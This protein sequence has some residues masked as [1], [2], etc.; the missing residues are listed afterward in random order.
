EQGSVAV[1]A[2]VE[3]RVQRPQT[4]FGLTDN[5]LARIFELVGKQVRQLVDGNDRGGGRQL[6]GGDEVLAVRRGIQAVGVLRYWNVASDLAVLAILLAAVEH[7]HLGVAQGDEVAG[8][9]FSFDG[10]HVEYHHPVALIA[11]GAAQIQR[12]FRVVAGGGGE[13]TGVIGVGIVEVA[14]DDDLPGHFHGFRVDRVVHGVAVLVIHGEILAIVRMRD[15]ELGVA[16]HVLGVRHLLQAQTVDGLHVGHGGDLVRFH[17]VQT[18]TRHTAVGLVVDEQV[19]AVVLAIGHGQV[20][21][22]AVAIEE[23]R[24]VAQY[25]TAL[26]GQT[27]AGGGIDVEYRD[28]HQLAHGGH[29]EDPHFALVAAGP[30]TVVG[31]QPAGADMNLGLRLLLGVTARLG[32]GFA[33]HHR[34]AEGRSRYRRPG[35]RAGAEEA[36]PAQSF[37]FRVGRKVFGVV[38]HV[39]LL[40]GPSSLTLRVRVRLLAP[41]ESTARPALSFHVSCACS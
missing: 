15:D 7:R 33:A 27:P 1:A 23:L 36:A 32:P 17:D 39:Q 3:G 41:P 13:T 20:R 40:I 19:F 22:V 14:I 18:D 35:H 21:V 28:T 38:A 37:G 2:A 26:V 25:G 8:L 31:I 4:Q 24:A 30:E 12:L 9:Q 11:H 34:T 29:T 10:L 16:E 5:D 6:A